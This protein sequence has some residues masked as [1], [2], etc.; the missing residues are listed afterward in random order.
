MILQRLFF[1][2]ILCGVMHVSPSFA[3]PLEKPKSGLIAH[4]AIYDVRMISQKSGSQVVDI[5]GKMFFEWKPSCDGYITNHRFNL[6]YDYAD[7]PTLFIN[8]DF[9]TFESFDG[10]S[11]NFS[12]RRKKDG[13]TYDELRGSATLDEMGKGKAV[14]T[15][16][17]GLSFDFK[18]PTVFSTTHTKSLIAAAKSN[19]K[20]LVK[21]TF[22]GSDEEGPV[23]VSA[24]IGKTF[25]ADPVAV[26][27][28]GTAIDKASTSPIDKR[29]LDNGWVV[30][31]AF[32][33]SS[34][35]DDEALSDYELTMKFH[36][37]GIISDM[38]IDYPDFT[39]HQKL[40]GLQRLP[41]TSCASAPS[42]SNAEIKP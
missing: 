42:K 22:D 13:D 2:M 40:V 41:A 31:L 8:S 21:Q 32:F 10:R 3:V 1:L 29:L 9:S 24:L 12:S 39:V 36:E 25:D 11:L 26:A 18:K 23:E 27:A 38:V 33:P 30:R 28:A 34:Q 35:K 20:I 5:K 14:F 19:Q 6:R 15:I 4:K 7:N 16:P 37:N 17:D